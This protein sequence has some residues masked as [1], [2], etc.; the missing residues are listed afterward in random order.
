M[1]YV[2]GLD[3]LRALAVFF[4][5]IEHW[6]WNP[7]VQ[8][9]TLSAY[10]EHIF[11]LKTAF[12]VNLFFVLSGFL[13]TGILLNEKE[14]Y[15]G[16]ERFL[17]IKNFFIRRSLRIF[18]IYY[19]FI[20]ICY[21]L[22]FPTVRAHL[23][24][25]VTYTANI[26]IYKLNRPIEISH[27]WTLCV[28]EQ[29][30]IIWPWLIIFVNNKYLKNLFIFIIIA[31][32]ASRYVTLYVYHRDY[33]VLVY[34][35]IDSFGVGA[36]YAY[37]RLNEKS[38]IKFESGYKI[39]LPIIIYFALMLAPF[40]GV[41]IFRAYYH[42]LDSAIALALIMFAINNKREWIRK[43]I[44]EN[45]VLNYIGKISYGIYLYHYNLDPLYNQFVIPYLQ[46]HGVNP[47]FTSYYFSYGMKLILLLTVCSLSYKFIELPLLN[48]KKKFSYGAR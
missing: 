29:F 34:Q 37:I 16:K 15:K 6:G 35:M 9:N 47:L 14:K 20:L 41:A 28:E 48:L 18:P 25:F 42:V 21:L 11:L 17:I 5:I 19:L 31:G 1:K 13:I 33:P 2:K 36:L 32:L 26:L 46:K 38:R 12:G 27:I 22:C 8:P 23:I 24:Y 45:P 40:P 39:L 10:I 44:L 43:Y 3:T 7:V 30:Y 4:V